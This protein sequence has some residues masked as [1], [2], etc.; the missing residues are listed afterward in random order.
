M[1]EYEIA[2]I[3]LRAFE[4]LAGWGKPIPPNDQCKYPTV[5]TW[6]LEERMKHA[7]ELANWAIGSDAT[8]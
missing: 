1:T 8:L 4:L 2:Q 6:N 7:L 3:R 5:E